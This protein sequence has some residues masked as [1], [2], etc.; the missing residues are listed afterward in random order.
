MLLRKATLGQRIQPREYCGGPSE[1]FHEETFD[2]T[3]EISCTATEFAMIREYFEGFGGRRRNPVEACK[4]LPQG[5]V[6]GVW[7][8]ESEA[9]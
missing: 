3:L 8:P 5:P 1:R 9:T 7:E 4:A 2:L 6:E